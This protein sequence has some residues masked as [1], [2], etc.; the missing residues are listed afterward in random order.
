MLRTRYNIGRHLPGLALLLLAALPAVG[1]VSLHVSPAG[2]DTNTGTAAAPFATLERA[3]AA[4]RELLHARGEAA[5]GVTVWLHGGEYVRADTFE[6]SAADSGTP[7]APVVWCA[8]TGE[9]VRV[10]GAASLSPSWFAPVTEASPA[11]ARLD[12]AARG[13]VLQ[14]D[15]AAHGITNYGRLAVRGFG[16]GATAALELFCNQEP[17]P[18][19]RYPDPEE[20]D[21]DQTP[22]NA[23]IVVFGDPNPLDVTGRYTADGTSD[24]V[25]RFRRD[26]LADGRQYYLYR[27]HWEYQG[28][29][30]RAWFLSTDA[31]NGY[32]A[33]TN[34]WWSRYAETFGRM[35]PSAQSGS[36]GTV[37]LGD[38]RRISHGFLAVNAVGG[39]NVFSYAGERPARWAQ[40]EEPW[41]HGFWRYHWA[42]L[43][44]AAVNIAT[45]TRA[46]TLGGVPTFGIQPGQPFYAYNLLEEITRPG[47]WYLNRRDATLYFWPPAPLAG[48]TVEVSLLAVPL[49]RLRDATN[50]TV[51]GLVLDGSRAELAVIEG[52]ARCTIERCTLRNAGANAA[53]VS[54]TENGV[55]RCTIVNPGE[56]G[57]ILSGGDRARL[58]PC[59]NFVRNCEIRRF[60]RFAWTYHPAVLITAGSVGCIVTHNRM[61]DAP[62]TAVLFGRCNDCTISYNDIGDVCRWSSDAGAVYI[63]RDWA[64]RGNE[65]C[66]NFI[67]DVGSVF[68][69]CG[70]QGIYLDDCQ[71]GVRVFGNVL[72][73]ISH[74]GI[75]MGGGRDNVMEN[76]VIA[77]CGTGIGADG[78]GTGWMF[79]RGGSRA[80]WEDLQ[81][82]PYRSAAWSAAYP[83]CAAIP[84]NW[85]EIVRDHWLRPQNNVFS[86]NLGFSNRSWTSQSDRAYADF[87]EVRDNVTDADPHFVDEAAGNLALRPDSPAFGIPGFRPIPFAEIG[88]VPAAR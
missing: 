4:V 25:N 50:V 3:R 27:R 68:E 35:E 10:T 40:A 13:H 31:K 56:G 52:G 64:A 1:A 54:G 79:E 69:G 65:V 76:N 16:R 18:L 71:S 44:L 78:R 23:A 70:T 21:P 8:A 5:G 7:A 72:Y 39:T 86:R 34:P 2:S 87:R 81:R 45:N 53:R 33:N 82:Q 61:R 17:M 15:L 83:L 84:T 85:N 48:A 38:P 37:S 41:L 36:A 47:E 58:V 43:H 75:Q 26:A 63:G 42:D 66:W 74:M 57:V 20:H 59:R 6:L 60:S 9:A 22:T 49:W 24:G 67:H 80:L 77:R 62:H 28:V 88:P 11:W 19:A 73:R 46:I 30:H 29:W 51:R 12:P 14:A 55:E 32:P